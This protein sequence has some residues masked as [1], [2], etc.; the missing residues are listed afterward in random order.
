MLLCVHSNIFDAL[1]TFFVP[2]QFCFE[3]E[4]YYNITAMGCTHSRNDNEEAYSLRRKEN[5]K[6]NADNDIET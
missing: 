4:I 6:L 5:Q 1:P 2:F 3:L